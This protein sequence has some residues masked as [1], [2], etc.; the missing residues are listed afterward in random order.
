MTTFSEPEAATAAGPEPAK[1]SW[2]QRLFSPI[3]TLKLLAVVITAGF[4]ILLF[5]RSIFV[6]VQPGQVGVMFDLLFGGTQLGDAYKEGLVSKFPWNRFYV[7]EARLQPL[8]LEM[9]A[10]TKEGM[11]VTVR[12][13]LLF[14]PRRDKIPKLHQQIGPLYRDQVLLP[15]VTGA[16]RQMIALYDSHVM[17]TVKYDNMQADVE[18]ELRA[19]PVAELIDFSDFIITEISLPQAVVASIERK[20]A[21]EQSMFAYNFMVETQK[22]EAQ[23]LRIEAEG[24]RGFY[25]VVGASLTPQLLTWRG[26][27]ATVEVARSPNAKVVIMGN[28]KGQLPLILGGDLGNTPADSGSAGT[29]QGIGKGALNQPHMNSN[30]AKEIAADMAERHPSSPPA[31]APRFD[32]QSPL[33]PLGATSQRQLGRNDLA[34]P[35]YSLEPGIG[36]MKV[37]NRAFPTRPD[38]SSPTVASGT[39]SN[40]DQ[41][42]TD[43]AIVAG[44]TIPNNVE[45]R[46]DP[47]VQGA[48][49]ANGPATL[50]GEVRG[51]APAS[52]GSGRLVDGG[53]GGLLKRWWSSDAGG[54]IT[55]APQSK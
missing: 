30:N 19:H 51:S 53:L 2:L 28:G 11:A 41:A 8:K 24:L 25:E 18:K 10:Y 16:V 50:N 22:K 1:K 32:R 15:L 44:P 39:A 29:K 13:T 4:L 31:A 47:A 55:A 5:W 48:R 26:I 52:T 43:R 6:T 33:D 3:N 49:S 9:I 14:K 42:L 12:A 27:E 38:P 45:I 40:G 20:L 35:R 36:G 23:R 7:Y 21:Q 37:P 17:Y 34:V 54:N 46:A